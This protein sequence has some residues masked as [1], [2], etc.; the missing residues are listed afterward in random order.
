ALRPRQGGRSDGRF[1]G[2]EQRLPWGEV[3][4][5]LPSLASKSRDF[6]RISPINRQAVDGAPAPA[7]RGRNPAPRTALP[8]ALTTSASPRPAPAARRTCRPPDACAPAPS[9]S[10]PRTAA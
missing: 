2:Q 10:G 1:H 7:G 9:R 6:L 8:V 5:V 4:H 3:N